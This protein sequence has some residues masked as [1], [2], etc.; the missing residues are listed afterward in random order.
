MDR[1]TFLASLLGSGLAA[2]LGPRA[3][4]AP[5]QPGQPPPSPAPPEVAIT[6]DDFDVNPDD[7]ALL[8][9]DERSGALLEALAAH[10]GLKCAAFVCG[11]RAAGGASG[12][13][14]RAWNDAGHLLANHTYSHAYYPKADF[15][16]FTADILRCEELLR[17]Y[18]RFVKRFRH[19][20]LKE[21]K[22]PEQ[23]DRLRAFL[24][25]HGYRSGAVTI[26]A[27]DWAIDARL[28]R[29]LARDPKADLA[30]YRGFYLDHLSDRAAFYDDLA[31]RAVGRPIRHTLLLHHN[32]LNA[33]FL[34]DLLERFAARGWRLVDAAAAF[35][36]PVFEVRPNIAPAGESLV[37]AI[38]KESGRFDAE[39]RY[40]GEDESYETARM[41]ELG[42]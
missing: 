11:M 15:D 36:D 9:L 42:L 27:S 28:R 37:W 14:L 40:P 2:T 5:P 32:V 16:E 34:G 6:I 21:G 8:S 19:P 30:P 22:S 29:R 3:L 35:E 7:T 4:A 10:R 41:D 24:D 20:Y 1:R 23:R 38:A 25:E 18:P 12:R 26:D 17:P 31:R 13:R 39:L 33:L